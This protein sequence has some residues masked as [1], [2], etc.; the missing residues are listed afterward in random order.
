MKAK[1]EKFS[2]PAGKTQPKQLHFYQQEG[3]ESDVSFHLRCIPGLTYIWVC[4]AS[5]QNT[6]PLVGSNLG[7]R[8][9]MIFRNRKLRLTRTRR[10]LS[11]ESAGRSRPC[12]FSPAAGPGSSI[13]QCPPP[14]RPWPSPHHPRDIPICIRAVQMFK[15]S[16]QGT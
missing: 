16:K 10:S 6:C 14:A 4:P 1:Q 5:L 3:L 7:S 2:V 15:S 9:G 12:S 8:T 11:P 13:H